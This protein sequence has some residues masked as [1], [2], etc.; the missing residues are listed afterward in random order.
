MNVLVKL[1]SYLVSE[2]INNLLLSN[3]HQG[4]VVIHQKSIPD[5]F[6]PDVILV[7]ISSISQSLFAG[8]PTSKVLLIDTGVEKERIIAALLSYPIHGVLSLDTEVDLFK[9]ALQVVNEGQIWVDNN[10]LKAFL[11]QNTATPVSVKTDSVT[12]REKE[13]ID[14]VC[15]GYTN[16]EIASTLSLSEHTIKAHLN[17]IFRKYNTS[18]RSKLITMVLQQSGKKTVQ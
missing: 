8:F 12:E 7:D 5:G 11:R 1:S 3:G 10:T 18:S 16:R 14:F 15:Q 9:K 2:G 6:V 17:R 13:I 4:Q